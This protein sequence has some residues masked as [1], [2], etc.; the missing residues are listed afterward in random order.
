MRPPQSCL[1]NTYSSGWDTGIFGG[2]NSQNFGLWK[3]KLTSGT[4]AKLPRCVGGN[5][6]AG[7]AAFVGI[8]LG[9][10]K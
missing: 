5:R 9:E 4:G 10:T 7:L 1:V 8:V 3:L 6:V 2:G